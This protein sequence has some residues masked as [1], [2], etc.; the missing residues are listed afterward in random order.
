[1][2][3]VPLPPP[4]QGRQV[5]ALLISLDGSVYIGNN[6]VDRPQTVCPRKKAGFGRGE[7]W[8]LCRTICGQICHAEEAAIKAAGTNAAGGTLYLI[9]H[10]TVCEQC[11]ELLETAGVGHVVIVG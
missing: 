2:P 4:C 3:H 10:D 6:G 11:T 9:G 7:G 1:M 8:E 5:I